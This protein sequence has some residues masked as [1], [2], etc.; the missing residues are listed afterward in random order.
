MTRKNRK[1][2]NELK[3]DIESS[4][5]KIKE[6]RKG[7]GPLSVLTMIFVVL[8]L[9]SNI[10]WNWAWVLS[11]L[12]MPMAIIIVLVILIGVPLALFGKL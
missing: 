6:R 1:K 2:Y 11:P 7:M 10:T 3:K 8:K 12:W 5:T 4:I 9:T